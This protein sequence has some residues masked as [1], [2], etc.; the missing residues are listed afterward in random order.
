MD[1]SKK[2]ER[3]PPSNR[4]DGDGQP[5]TEFIAIGGGWWIMGSI[6]EG[7]GEKIP[8]PTSLLYLE[9]HHLPLSIGST[10]DY[11]ATEMQ[12]LEPMQQFV[13]LEDR[14]IAAGEEATN[15]LIFHL[16]EPIIP[17]ISMSYMLPRSLLLNIF[18]CCRT[19]GEKWQ[20]IRLRSKS[21]AVL[22][23]SNFPMWIK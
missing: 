13:A 20:A 17:V 23:F 12:E 11:G 14:I 9:R 16:L 3:Y 22:L 19:M 1:R 2:S 4:E 10:M 6:E 21:T 8:V 15:S 7:I 18:I 5:I